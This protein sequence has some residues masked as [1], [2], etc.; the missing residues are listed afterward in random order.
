[1]RL[2]FSGVSPRDPVWQWEKSARALA[3]RDND[4]DDILSSHSPGLPRIALSLA[5]LD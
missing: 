4:A 3:L 2:G 1:M 5:T